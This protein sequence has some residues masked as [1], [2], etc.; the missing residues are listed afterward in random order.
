MQP[1]L[2]QSAWTLV[3]RAGGDEKQ[4][5]TQGWSL[6]DAGIPRG[7]GVRRKRP[8]QVDSQASDS[9]W[10]T[11][12]SWDHCRRMRR[13]GLGSL[14]EPRFPQ[15]SSQGGWATAEFPLVS[16][17]R[18]GASKQS[19]QHSHIKQITREGTR[20]T[21]LSPHSL[22]GPLGG[23]TPENSEPSLDMCEKTQDSI[24]PNLPS[25]LH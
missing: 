5:D 25:V 14:S 3:V 6:Q 20:D 9:R 10:G 19:R 15:V 12:L 8:S 23:T 17:P 18:Y 16:S 2:S 24:S 4:M 21:A 7:C 1:H 13:C 22:A 11:E